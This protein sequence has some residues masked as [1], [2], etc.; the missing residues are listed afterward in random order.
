[1]VSSEL[2]RVAIL[3]LELWWEGLED[4]S[5]LY[6]GEGN[7]KGMLD[8]LIPLH[9]QLEGGP[10]TRRE[11]E[12][13]RSFGRDLAEAHSFVKEYTRLTKSNGGEIPSTGGFAQGS[14]EQGDQSGLTTVRQ[15]SLIH[16]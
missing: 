11:T 8:V 3:W 5:R 4:A 1:M 2:I 15:L 9:E 10:K 13:Y 6:F 7:V 12:F 16:I 14:P